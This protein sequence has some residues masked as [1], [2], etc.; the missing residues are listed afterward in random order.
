MLPA[1]QY[2]QLRHAE[3]DGEVKMNRELTQAY[4]DSRGLGEASA[5]FFVAQGDDSVK[6]HE[7]RGYIEGAGIIAAIRVYSA[8]DALFAAA[9]VASSG[10]PV[11]ELLSP[12]RKLQRLSLIY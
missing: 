6:K 8:D 5:T 12:C 1:S 3:A 7:V 11:V 10:I 9:A 2:S 4:L